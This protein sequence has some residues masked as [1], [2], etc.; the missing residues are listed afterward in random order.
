MGK[1]PNNQR[2]L[3]FGRVQRVKK[4]KRGCENE[5]SKKPTQFSNYFLRVVVG[6]EKW[7]WGAGV[8]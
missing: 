4:K 2:G 8:V 6:G 3:S 5:V 7:W 1:F